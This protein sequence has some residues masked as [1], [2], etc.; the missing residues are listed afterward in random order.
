[1]E[2]EKKTKQTHKQTK[3]QTK[4]K[5]KNRAGQPRSDCPGQ[6]NFALGQVT[7]EVQWPQGQVK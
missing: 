5:G 2:S 4:E 6:V 3:K 1:M 7:R